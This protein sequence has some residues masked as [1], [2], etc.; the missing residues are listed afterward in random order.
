MT[1]IEANRKIL[2]SLSKYNETFP[3]MRFCQ[4]LW[5]LGLCTFD[6]SNNDLFYE[7]SIKT[8]KRVN[9]RL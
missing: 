1:R 5:R 9:D 4:L 2:E 7:E 8:L 3:D 6:E